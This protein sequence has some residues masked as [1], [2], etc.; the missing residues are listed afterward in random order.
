MELF[1]IPASA[2]R[3]V[4]QRPWYVLSCLG[5]GTY[6]RPVAANRKRV[7]HVVTEA[8]FLSRYLDGPLHYT[9]RH[10]TVL[11]RVECAVK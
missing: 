9:R 4:Q 5:D 11:K 3:L 2:P 10:I 6:K 1:F 8:D 7:A